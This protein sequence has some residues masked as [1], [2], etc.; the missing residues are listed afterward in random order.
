VT[1]L[2]KMGGGGAAIVQL[3]RF[4]GDVGA[5]I[6]VTDCENTERAQHYGK[7]V[8]SNPIYDLGLRIL[9]LVSPRTQ[10]NLQAGR[11]RKWA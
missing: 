9:A 4:G 2:E 11:M 1:I 3:Q 5:V 8:H 7:S 6:A 10:M